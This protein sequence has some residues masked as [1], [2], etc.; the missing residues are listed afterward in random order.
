MIKSRFSSVKLFSMILVAI[1]IL[2][3]IFVSPQTVYASS[4]IATGKTSIADSELPGHEAFNGNDNKSNT[5]WSAADTND[6]HYWT[7]DFGGLYELKGTEVKWPSSTVYKYRVETS[8]DNSHWTLRIDKSNNKSI[9]QKQEDNFVGVARYVKI[10][11]LDVQSNDYASICDFKAFGTAFT[12][13]SPTMIYIA[14]DSTA[15]TYSRSFAP[16]TGWGQCIEKY[17]KKDVMFDNRAIGARS[18]KSFIVE[19]R[20]DAILSVIRPN[21]YL[22]IQFAHNDATNIPAR[23]TDPY[24][25]Y[26][27]YLKQYVTRTRALGAIPILITPVARLNFRDGVFINDFPD[28][29]IAMKQVAA[30]T[31]TPCIDMMNTCIDYYTTMGYD[32]VFPNYLVSSNGTDYTHFTQAGANMIANLLSQKIKA[33]DLP[34]SKYI[35]RGNGGYEKKIIF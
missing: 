8:T 34:I 17:F 24:T 9:E 30:E 27:D 5:Y 23:H 28:Y 21:D 19:G 1:F 14:G 12:S 32:A 31:N 26:K 7:V 29:V 11:I 22:F 16:Q 10:I 25:T 3:S 2:A 13:S 20:L 15:Q 4:N 33:L 35:R 18:S 6:N